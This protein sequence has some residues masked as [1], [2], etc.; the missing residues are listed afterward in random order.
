M[1]TVYSKANCPQCDNAKGFL[2]LNEIQF[3]EVMVDQNTVA[4][5]WLM[6]QGHRSVPQLYLNGELFV[7][8]G[9]TGLSK[10]TKD[11]LKEKLN[12][13]DNSAIQ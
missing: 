6:E 3:K 11:Q 12:V 4:R 7:E 2:K 1:I 8:N 9:Y 10:L 5:E 13:S